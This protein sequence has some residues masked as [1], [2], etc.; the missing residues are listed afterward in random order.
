METRNEPPAYQYQPLDQNAQGLNDNP[1]EMTYRDQTQQPMG[2]PSQYPPT[3]AYPQAAPP[4][5]TPP[6]MAA[7]PG[8]PIN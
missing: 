3:A 4:L 2:A 6:P 5:Y 7:Q 8:I 1:S